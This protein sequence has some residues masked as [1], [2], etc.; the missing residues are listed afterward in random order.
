[1]NYDF[2]YSNTIPKGVKSIFV[3]GETFTREEFLKKREEFFNK[4]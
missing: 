4:K 1:M 2:L 3:N